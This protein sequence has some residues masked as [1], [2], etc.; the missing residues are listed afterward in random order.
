MGSVRRN[1]RC[2]VA[3]GL[4]GSPGTPLARPRSSSSHANRSGR[5]SSTS[6]SAARNFHQRGLCGDVE[7]SSANFGLIEIRPAE[8]WG[9][10]CSARWGTSC[11]ARR[12]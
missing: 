11:T 3:A 4:H 6:R 8:S 5:N 10:G 7:V 1:S 2:G 9:A 12:R